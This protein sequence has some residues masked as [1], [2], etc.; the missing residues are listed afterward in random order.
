MHRIYRCLT[1]YSTVPNY[2]ADPNHSTMKVEDDIQ[3]RP[4][5]L[6]RTFVFCS[7][8]GPKSEG[9][10][11]KGAEVRL[12]GSSG[13]SKYLFIYK[14]L[15]ILDVFSTANEIENSKI[16]IYTLLIERCR[17]Q[18]LTYFAYSSWNQLG[19]GQFI[20]ELYSRVRCSITASA[21][22]S[23]NTTWRDHKKK[24]IRFSSQTITKLPNVYKNY[25]C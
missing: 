21:K 2:F 25:L 24:G 9:D 10:D 8:W 18:L 7:L 15:Q 3:K 1:N 17:Y 20:S 12:C 4:L 16:S 19:F 5:S 14:I 23:W 11:Q 22:F 13:K 6:S